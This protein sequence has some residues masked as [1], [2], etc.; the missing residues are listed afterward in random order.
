MRRALLVILFC[1]AL[2]NVGA[3]CPSVYDYDGNL[4]STPYWF[5]CSGGNFSLNLQPSGTWDNYTIDWGDGS[6]AATGVTWSSPTVLQHTYVAAVDTF[7]VSVTEG[8]TGCSIVGVVVMEQ[9]T[10]ASIQ[11]PGNVATQVCA[12]AAVEFLNSST[13]VS[14]TTQFTWNFGD[15]SP[16]I[17]FGASNFNEVVS[18]LYNSSSAVNCETT[19]SLTASNYCNILQGNPSVA[20]FNP[21]NV[22]TLDQ[23]QIGASAITQCFPDTAFTFNNTSIRNC[24]NQGNTFQRQERWNFGNYW[25]QGVDSVTAWLPWPPT[26]PQTIAFP[27]IGDYT[28]TLSDSSYCGVVEDSI[29]V[30]IVPPPVASISASTDTICSGGQVTFYQGSTG[31][32]QSY[33]WNFGNNNNWQNLGS[34]NVNFTFNTA[35][36]FVVSN[37]VFNNGWG[38][39]CADTATVVVTVLPS[40]TASITASPAQACDSLITALNVVSSLGILFEWNL[41]AFGTYSGQNPDTLSITAPGN[42]TV[43][44]LVTGANGCTKTD[45][46]VLHV[47]ATPVPA[48]TVTSPCVGANAIFTNISVTAPGNPITSAQWTFGD[49]GT[50]SQLTPTHVYA[51][52][53]TFPITLNISTPYCSASAQGNITVHPNPTASFTQD[54]ISGCQPLEVA[55]T[56]ASQGATSYSWNFNDG[57]LSTNTNE[58]HVFGNNTIYNLPYNVVLTAINEFG[59]TNT[60]S[61]VVT[62][63]GGAVANFEIANNELGCSTAP[64]GFNNL[65][66]GASSY[67]WNFGDGTTSIVE[68]P[69]HAYN[70]NSGFLWWYDVTLVAYSSGGCLDTATLALPIY[71]ILDIQLPF[72]SLEGCSPFSAQMPAIGGVQGFSWD[73][74]DGFTSSLISPIHTYNNP[75]NAAQN[76]TVSL[77]GESAFGC[78]DST[79]F[80]VTVYLQPEASFSQTD[81]DGCAPITIG[82]TNTSTN[83]TTYVW[84]YGD[85]SAST[86]VNGSHLY[87]NATGVLNIWNVSLIA[88][89]IGGCADTMSSEVLIYPPL[90]FPLFNPIVS[91]CSP[92]TFEAPLFPGVANYAWSFGNGDVSAAAAPSY[93]YENLSGSTTDY[94]IHLAGTSIYGCTDA[95]TYFV[96]VYPE[97]NA[98][99]TYSEISGCSPLQVDFQSTS[100]NGDQFEWNYGDGLIANTPNISHT[101]YNINGVLNTFEAEL[102]VTSTL[103]CSDSASVA[104]Q[105]SPSLDLQWAM[106]IVVGCSPFTLQTPYMPGG[107]SYFWNFGD[108]TTSI[109]TSPTHTYV[110]N[111]L[112]VQNFTVTC[113]VENSFGCADSISFNVTVNPQAI[114]NLSTQQ[115]S[116]CSPLNVTFQNNSQYALSYNWN[117]GNGQTSTTTAATHDFLY[118]NNTAQPVT[119]AAVLQANQVSTCSSL[120]TVQITIY[121]SVTASFSWTGAACAVVQAQFNNTSTLGTSAEWT[122]GDG[123]YSNAFNP[124]HLYSNNSLQDLNY[125]VSL[126]STSVF[127]CSDSVNH[128]LTVLYSPTAIAAIDTVYGCYPLNVDLANASQGA[129][130]YSWEYGDA[131][132]STTSAAQHTHTYFNLSDQPQTY[133]ITLTVEA[134]NGC[135]DVWADQVTV[136]PQVVA[137]ADVIV[138][139]CNP[140]EVVFDNQSAGA[141]SYFWN[142]GNGDTSTSFNEQG[143]FYNP[144][145]FDTTFVV[146]LTATNIYG[147]EVTTDFWVIVHP[148]PTAAFTVTP[149]VQTWPSNS[150]TFQENSIGTNLGYNWTLEDG[151]EYYVS[152]PGSHV[153]PSW[154]TYNIELIVNEGLCTDTTAQS[155]TII[156]PAPVALFEG[157]GEGCVPLTVTLSNLSQYADSYEWFFSDGGY[158]TSDNPV[159]TFYQTGVFGATL[160]VHGFD[161]TNDT[162]ELTNLFIV[163]ANAVASFTVNPHQVVV[164][165]QPILCQNASDNATIFEWSFGD[166]IVSNE[167][168]PKHFY[169]V[170]GVYSIQLIANN[171]FNCPDTLTLV[172]VVFAY[173][174]GYLEYPNAFTPKTSGPSD[175][176]YDPYGYTNDIFCPLH[177]GVV[178]YE[179]QIFNKWGEQIF[180]T[181]DIHRGWDGYYRG[182]LSKEDVYAWK[183]SVTFSNGTSK[184]MTG[185][186]TLLAR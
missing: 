171:Q 143:D 63:L 157:N 26:L 142:L 71:P 130:A 7:V 119:Y 82:F 31:T 62:V 150:V 176:Y 2:Y 24:L 129:N 11:I 180:E 64:V 18:H 57:P 139:G 168:S 179:L 141:T 106:P 133:Q 160:V 67:A 69:N 50:S 101:Y 105:V 8:G 111:S 177:K 86:G 138:S 162:L 186:L 113:Y 97:V 9:P 93:T 76:F 107:S 175:G 53:G 74:G 75:T 174:D 96:H 145:P 116:G 109:S 154:G 17:E 182:V 70:N 124:Y 27:G 151:S 155:I 43:S 125:T 5:G 144:Y 146:S 126:I 61:S 178:L 169:D 148:F 35:G 73:F 137:D 44:V 173:G 47:Y 136:L 83:A 80:P 98:A 85:G 36:T 21:V 46:E 23:A 60:Q 115:Y 72:T 25:G 149:L 161:G 6:S 16:P 59:C 117:Y 56:N 49:G 14:E 65:S 103:G 66:L 183:V 99:F 20:T 185:D 3:Q 123:F 128:P 79:S 104:V 33:Q 78:F 45:T 40:P 38:S 112:S 167:I 1:S 30:H 127:G 39:A 92:F 88:S 22:W 41:G 48:F 12:P 102:T 37:R 170:E 54:V 165:D 95:E 118:V 120:D 159:Y 13:N 108:G 163:H 68:D 81:D 184:I 122:F 140:V 28:V 100:L 52:E 84:N 131:L 15:G 51:A 166:G 158:T 34:G 114:S 94:T 87:T 181:N 89:S 19:V 58:L 121:P 90:I 153:F 4:V 10:N 132:N 172:D 135:T 42:Y 29:T 91:G 147:C 110:N 164:P 55:F 156:P 77:V 134:P 152:N 32:N